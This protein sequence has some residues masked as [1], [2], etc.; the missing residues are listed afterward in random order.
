M[1]DA[2]TTPPANK[3]I[4]RIEVHNVTV[5]IFPDFRATVRRRF[6]DK[7]GKTGFAQ[8]LRPVDWKPAREALQALEDWFASENAPESA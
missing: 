2:T 6:T 1:A 4:H 3:P 7:D 8:S 5:S